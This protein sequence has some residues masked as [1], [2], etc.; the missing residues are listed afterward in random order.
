M[1]QVGGDLDLPEK[2]IRADRSRQLGT[3]DLH[4]HL[5]VMLQVLGQIDRRH[6]TAAYLALDSVA[7]RKAGFQT[8]EGVGQ[9]AA[10]SVWRR[11]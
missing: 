10:T 8:V 2:P 4:R 6:A 1:L 3:Q 9:G 5:A 11:F 7:V